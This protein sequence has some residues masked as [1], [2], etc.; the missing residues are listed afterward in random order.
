MK[1]TGIV[2]KIDELGRMV[3]PKEIRDN[4][5]I[6]PNDPMEFFIEGERIIVTKYNE[7]CS[8]CGGDD[9]LADFGEKRLCSACIE[10]IKA[11]F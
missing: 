11:Q 10:A 3:V 6:K 5:G 2:R 4:M 1:S 7:G 9:N 8:L